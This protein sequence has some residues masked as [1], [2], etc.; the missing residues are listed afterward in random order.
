MS[1]SILVYD[2]KI[3]AKVEKTRGN[4]VFKNLIVWATGSVTCKNKISYFTRTIK[5]CVNARGRICKYMCSRYRT[6]SELLTVSYNIEL[7]SVTWQYD[8]GGIRGGSVAPLWRCRR[9]EA[10]DI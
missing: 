1:V 4:A 3:L 7:P 9:M 8:R 5:N 10:V 6:K 2:I